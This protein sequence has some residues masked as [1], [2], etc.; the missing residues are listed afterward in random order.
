MAY[1]DSTT[2]SEIADLSDEVLNNHDIFKIGKKQAA[3][4]LLI[5]LL[6]QNTS[7]TYDSLETAYRACAPGEV[8]PAGSDKFWNYIEQQFLGLKFEPKEK[9]TSLAFQVAE[10]LQKITKNVDFINDELKKLEKKK[11]DEGRLLPKE[12]YY[13]NQLEYFRNKNIDAKNEIVDFMANRAKNQA[14]KDAAIPPTGYVAH[15]HSMTESWLGKRR[16][17]SFGRVF[18]DILPDPYDVKALNDLSNKFTDL[19]V[20]DY[21]QVIKELEKHPKKFKK[22]AKQYIAGPGYI[23]SAND[24]L[25]RWVK[26]SHILATRKKVIA[27]MINHYEKKD[28]ISFVSMAPLQI[29]GI[30]ADICREIGISEVQLD[31]SSLNEK[32]DHIDGKMNFFYFEYY[33]FK[34]P[35]FRNLVAHGGLIDGNLEETAI[36]LLLDLLPVCELAVSKDLPI[37]I[38]LEILKQAS[39]G[40][41][42]SMVDWLAL[43]A[44]IEIPDFYKIS[45]KVAQMESHCTSPEFWDYLSTELEKL[46]DVKEL[47]RSVPIKTASAL[48]HKGVAVERATTFLKN[49]EKTLR[50]AIEKRK[51][52]RD[53]KLRGFGLVPES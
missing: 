2:V 44:N 17:Y 52:H 19:S 48:K 35:V 10:D 49:S 22:I 6:E 33:A 38:N 4:I 30:F 47:K 37:N 51:A 34:F 23:V 13:R 3:K 45:G 1:N 24:K 14:M 15:I 42:K 40:K 32:L 20:S 26:E 36:H 31:L 29:E 21:R 41:H 18:S 8:I 27:T 28:Y 43:S 11:K 39:E 25:K 9:F 46:D 16:P 5:K 53:R 12:R 50:N 7:A